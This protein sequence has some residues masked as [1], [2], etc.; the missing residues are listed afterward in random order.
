M[1]YI[2]FN[3]F[4]MQ[5]QPTINWNKQKTSG[6]TYVNFN[7]VVSDV[8]DI[9][10]TIEDA[11]TYNYTPSEWNLFDNV[12]KPVSKTITQVSNKASNTSPS[13]THTNPTVASTDS[14]TIQSDTLNNAIQKH[15]GEKY[16]MAKRYQ[17]GYSDCT[18]FVEKVYGDMGIS[19]KHL[20]A[21]GVPEKLFNKVDPSNIKPGDV[22]FL[23]YTKHH[24][25][26]TL[27]G[28]F[29]KA[30]ID[31]TH[32][33][34]VRK[35]LGNG[36]IEVAENSGGGRSKINIWQISDPR[37]KQKGVLNYAKGNSGSNEI[38]FF[39]RLKQGV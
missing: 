8:G 29:R 5:Y 23:T 11:F 37:K 16:S 9:Q 14:I 15:L 13:T 26:A 36:L 30:G 18:S 7:D 19:I 20:A 12:F 3:K 34:I 32:A 28:Q 33:A 10:K 31:H 24:G 25:S 2:D 39:G 1:E 21:N 17:N 38:L 4:F 27:G 35:I 22:V 6:Q